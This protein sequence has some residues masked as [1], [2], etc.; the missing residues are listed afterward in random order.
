MAY[1]I[2]VDCGTQGT[3]A[4]IYDPDCMEFLGE[5]YAPH[6]IAAN[7]R[8]GREQDPQWWIDALNTAMETALASLDSGKRKMIRGIGV[9]GQQHG[10]VILD[11]GKKVLRRAKL[12]NDTETSGANQRLIDAAG[13]PRGVIEKIGTAI[14]VGYTASKLVWL[15]EH[16]PEVFGRIAYVFNPKDY[17]NFYLTGIIATD[18]GSASGTGYY[19]TINKEWNDTMVSLI[20]PA[21]KKALP[22]VLGDTE[23][24]GPIA[25]AVA[26]RFGLDRNCIVAPGSGDNMMAAVGTGNVE[27]GIATM[28]LGTSGVLSIFTD[29]KPVGYP[30]IIQIQN[31]IPGGWIPTICTMNA[32]S[33]ST[34]V[35]ELFTL[36]L[37]AFDNDMAAAPIGCGGVTMLPFFNGERTPSL[38]SAKGSITGLT[39]TN[40]TRPNLIRSAAESVVFGLR[41]GCDLLREKGI[42]FR[43]LRLVGGGS[44]SAPWRQITADIFGADIIGVRGKEAG[45]FG[46]IIQAMAVC[47]EGSVPDLC[48]RHIQ[49]DERKQAHPDRGN[50]EKYEAVYRGYL[51]A[52][53]QLYGI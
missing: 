52:R 4:A 19:D 15:K 13:G 45:A 46:G 33:A 21:L 22:P 37:A 6:E 35:Q 41:W 32:T 30:E 38:P 17:I 20:D 34:A 29:Q 24:V 8:G 43:Q 16:E 2:G 10:L 1:Y 50:T 40:F 23:A 44:N 27:P 14:P 42:A 3:K 53:K 11:S 28:N 25:A 36:D 48:A 12:W 9:S 49:L 31:S 7:E 47:G 26:E 5:G 51:D 39:M 18:A